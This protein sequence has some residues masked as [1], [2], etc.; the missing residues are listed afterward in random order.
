VHGH[1][2]RAYKAALEAVSYAGAHGMCVGANKE[3]HQESSYPRS[4]T[5]CLVLP[6]Y[7]IFH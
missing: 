2:T 4:F 1:G 6:I 7:M 3:L 5:W